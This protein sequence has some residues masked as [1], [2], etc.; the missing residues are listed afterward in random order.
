MKRYR[1]YNKDLAIVLSCFGSVVEQQKY[2][3]LKEKISNEFEGA[4]VFVA[5][6]SRMVL[7]LLAK[8][9]QHYKN[10]IQTLADVDMLGYKNVIVASIN[11]FPTDEHNVVKS[12]VDG[13]CS[14]CPSNISCTDAIFTKTKYTTNAL[15]QLN[16]Q[17]AN[18]D[19]ANLYIIHGTPKLDTNGISSIEYVGGFLSRINSNN[20]YCSLEGAYP[21]G[22]LQ[23]TIIQEIKSKNLSKVKIIPLLLV[24]GN[25]YEKD[26]MEIKEELQKHFEVSLAYED[27]KFNL[28]EEEYILDIIKKEIKEQIKKIK[29]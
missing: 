2:L 14:F 13:F 25:H 23:D 29:G 28:L 22:V 9:N 26:A 6:Q 16:Q 8:Q 11:L 15:V 12:V 4:D 18:E 5:F 20:L 7:K 19:T 21:F 27:K 1:H 24:S 3:D 10:L 17:F